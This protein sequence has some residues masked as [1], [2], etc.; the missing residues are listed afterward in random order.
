MSL[1]SRLILLVNAM[2]A[3]AII[4]VSVIFGMLGSN[5]LIAQAED[6]ARL[7]AALIAEGAYWAEISEAEVEDVV[8]NEL[9]SQAIAVAELTRAAEAAGEVPELS[10]RYAEIAA[11]GFIDSIWLVRHGGEVLASSIGA[12]GALVTGDSLP[13]EVDQRVIDS[14]TSGDKFALGASYGIGPHGRRYVGVRVRPG[15][16]VFVLQRADF[17]RSMHDPT[18]LP[19]LVGALISQP[20]ILA[21][22]VFDDSLKLTAGAGRARA[23]N[24]YPTALLADALGDGNAHSDLDGP[25]LYVSA[26][27]TDQAGIAY[28]VALIELSTERLSELFRSNLRWGG[29]TALV[30]FLIGALFAALAARRI[31]RPVVAMTR[32]AMEVDERSFDPETLDT[33]A[34]GGGE[35][36]TLARVFRKMAIE[37][38]AREEHL[39]QQVRA[40]TQELQEK[41]TL[42]EGARKR[43]ESELEVARSLQAAILPQG[44]PQHPSY[45]GQATM[46]P[47]RELGGDFYDFFPLGE[48]KIGLVIADVSGKGVPAAFFM[49]IS[50]TTLRVAAR[51]FERPGDGLAAA[52][53]QICA[54]NPHEMFVTVFYGILDVVTGVLTY[55]NGGH[56]AP[57][58][59]RAGGGAPEM[60]PRTGGVALGVMAGLPY[61]EASATLAPGDTLFLY[62][63]GISEA[64]D[65]DGQEFTEARLLLSLDTASRNSVDVV[66]RKVTDAV[67]AFVGPAEQ[68]DDITCLVLRYLGPPTADDG[69]AG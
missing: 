45:A 60:L 29:V 2:L 19:K 53:D 12:Y 4:G 67:S 16:A 3:I 30:V 39:E 32:A 28:G 9:E 69:A 23:S 1:T 42:L 18:G 56:N 54:Q 50:R 17:L 24:D 34:A 57:V 25:I 31:V 49:A 35:L 26:P 48:N 11:K 65:V 38:Q 68:S 63:D 47:A 37:V 7:V 13:G 59:A 22:K 64:M 40:R 20:E 61:A 6:Q 66:L 14:V 44:M 55:A 15:L 5:A 52:N 10:T 21:V 46:V 36:G 41:N 51:D 58:L 27:I 8:R 33:L 62:T 43:V